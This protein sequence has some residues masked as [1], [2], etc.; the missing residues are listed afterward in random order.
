MRAHGEWT[1]AGRR[2]AP[3][4][5]LCSGE[6]ATARRICLSSGAPNGYSAAARPWACLI[7]AE[8]E[9][10]RL[11]GGLFL[12]ITLAATSGCAVMF[13]GAAGAGAGYGAAKA[14]NEQPEKDGSDA[15]S[16]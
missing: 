10:Q 7:G 5:D 9:M 13:A 6:A 3:G 8:T 2:S 4:V 14:A 12:A 15:E 11:L 1:F 16:E